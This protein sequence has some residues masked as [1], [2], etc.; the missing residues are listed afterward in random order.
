MLNDFYKITSADIKDVKPRSNFHAHNYLCGH[1]SGNVSDYA[2]EAVKNGLEIIGISDHCMPPVNTGDNYIT[3][4]EIRT[5][6][7]PQFEEAEAR[8]GDKIK[9]FAGAE[10]EYFSGNDLYYEKLL[11]DLNYLVLGQHM[12]FCGE[13]LRCSFYDG[14]DDANISAYCKQAVKGLRTGYFSLFAHP[15]VIFC[16]A[17]RIGENTINAFENL[18]TEAVRADVPLELNANGVRHNGFHYPSDL[19]VELCK[20][21]N[22]K[23]II[24]SDC[25]RPSELCDEY[26]LKLYAYAKKHDLNVVDGIELRR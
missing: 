22:A 8:F 10:I 4:S 1:A 13:R 18:V 16:G 2:E 20:K 14:V 21:H 6:Y 3:P 23:V 24:S 9:I 7:L 19:L 11:K 15:D 17:K 5:Q 26:V 12:Y 25:H